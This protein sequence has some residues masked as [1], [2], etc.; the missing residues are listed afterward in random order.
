MKKPDRAVGQSPG[1]PGADDHG[2]HASN[3]NGVSVVVCSRDRADFL[4]DA[5]VAVCA[6][7]RPQDEL[8]VVDS[9]SVDA[10]V[11]LV[12]VESG[13]RVVRAERPGLGYARNL[14][15]RAAT[16]SILAFT[17]DDCAPAPDWTARDPSRRSP[18]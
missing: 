12:A 4:R 18:A 11:A 3:P 9:A 8:V 5:L 10:S 2:P 7:L 6:A 13:A 15:W 16:R 17:D 1:L 14:G